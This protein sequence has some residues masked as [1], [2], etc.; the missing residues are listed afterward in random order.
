V[1][2]VLF[3]PPGC[4]KGTQSS[5]LASEINGQVLSTGDLFR[6]RIAQ[7][8]PLA[9]KLRAILSAGEL[10]SDELV[11]QMLLPEIHRVQA[12]EQHVI[13]DG[14]PR[15]LV[16]AQSLDQAGNVSPNHV[17]VFDV[18]DDEIV[19]RITGRLVHPQSGRVYH[20]RFN[21]PKKP[22]ID[23]VTGQKLVQREDDQPQTVKRRIAT[24][25]QNTQPIIN[26]YQEQNTIISQIDGTGPVNQV[27]DRLMQ[28]IHSSR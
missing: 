20:Q 10:V 8:D 4:G 23:D 21:P 5:R 14:F 15:T 17:I 12:A 27:T 26:Y 1:I 16:Q 6:Q 9:Q 3:G 11:I 22:Q 25:H 18:P 24:Y 28:V 2:L 7:S 13:L 19:D